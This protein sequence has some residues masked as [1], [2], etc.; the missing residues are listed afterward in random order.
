MLRGVTEADAVAYEQ[1]FVDYEVIRHLSAG[2]PWPYPV[3]GVRTFISDVVMPSQGRDRWIWGLHRK[4]E[5]GLMGTIELRR[6]GKP[7]HRGFWLGRAFWGHGY[8]TEAVIRVTNFA[9][10]E[11][12]FETLIFTNAVGNLRSHKIKLKTG[13]ELIGKAPAAFVDPAYNQHEL[14]QLTREQ[15]R[16]W[17]QQRAEGRHV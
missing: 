17:Q 12:G 10:E 7:G 5:E 4:G 6:Q 8:M 9:F 13:G 3:K 14:W 11:L 16:A 2:V 1:H 15:W